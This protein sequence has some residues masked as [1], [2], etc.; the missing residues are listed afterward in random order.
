[1]EK[2]LQDIGLTKGETKV[3]LTLLKVGETTTGKIIDNAGIS[4]GKIYEILEKLIKKGLVSYI[5]K[6][7]T[8]YFT[9]ASPNK[10]VDF[11]HEKEKQLKDKEQEIIKQLPL[12]LELEQT[13]QKDIEIQLFQG[14]KGIQTIIFDA[15]SKLTKDDEVLAMGIISQKPETF[16]LMWPKWHEQRIKK[17][18]NCKLLFSEKHTQYYKELKKMKYTKVK[19]IAGLTPSAIDI[20]GDHAFIFTF[21]DT[22]SCLS[23]KHPEIVQSFK[24]FFNNLWDLA[25]E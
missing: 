14:Y 15:L 2:L 20:M 9:A 3:Y 23:I 24:T 21:G 4:S 18:I 16:N 10:I 19:T 6:D 22:P 8:K 17:K 13:N 7:K 25:K 1:M 12:L 11:M 5:V